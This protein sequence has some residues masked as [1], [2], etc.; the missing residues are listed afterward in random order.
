MPEISFGDLAAGLRGWARGGTAHEQA[1][2]ELLIWHET[3]LR[4]PDFKGAA[5]TQRAA[6]LVAIINWYEARE[7]VDRGYRPL[8]YRPHGE[9]LPAA[10]GSQRAV[11]DLAVALGE[12]QYR[13]ASLGRVHKRKVAEA[14]ATA[15]GWRLEGDI[16][17][18]GHNHPDFIPGSPETCAACAR[19]AQDEGRR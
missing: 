8:A 5:I 15:C 13:L 18:P 3:W 17:E 6:G 4:R 10:S 12:D 11:L 1:A 14:F 7:F 9:T 16:P 19:E 2:V